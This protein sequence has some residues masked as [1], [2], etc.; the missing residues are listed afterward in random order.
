V[1][2]DPLELNRAREELAAARH[3]QAGAFAA[4][5]ISRAYYAAFY[6]AEAAL[7]QVGVTRSKHS[8]VI[9]GF[10]QR[11]VRAGEIDPEA[12]RLLRS[13]FDRRSGADYDWVDAPSLRDSETA[14]G[15][16]E[17]VV[18]AI[19]SWFDRARP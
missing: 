13:L 9:A 1:T 15:D 18:A 3:L 10:I 17:Q 2:D 19:A 8:A 5:A 14:I 16:A 12:G 6:A 7:T 4:Q 11:L